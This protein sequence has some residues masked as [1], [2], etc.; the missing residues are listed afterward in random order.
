MKHLKNDV[1]RYEDDIKRIKEEN[2]QLR[3]TKMKLSSNSDIIMMIGL[4]AEQRTLTRR[5]RELQ[6][7]KEDSEYDNQSIS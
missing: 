1:K 6:G 4:K 2:L 3:L 5:L 7:I